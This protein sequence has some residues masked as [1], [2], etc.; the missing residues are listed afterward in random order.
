MFFK[1]DKIEEQLATHL[2]GSV[3]KA[4]IDESLKGTREDIDDLKKLAT[5]HFVILAQIQK[6]GE[7]LQKLIGETANAQADVNADHHRRL[8]DLEQ[9]R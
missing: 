6:N 9:A 4:L 8:K 3:T 1:K 2:R 7:L 5:A